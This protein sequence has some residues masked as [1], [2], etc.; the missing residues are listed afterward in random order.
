MR[1]ELGGSCVLLRKGRGAAGQLCRAT[2]WE[3]QPWIWLQSPRS[4]P[5]LY[6]APGTPGAGQT[7]KA[8]QAQQ[9]WLGSGGE[10][11]CQVGHVEGLSPGGDSRH[12]RRRGPT[13]ETSLRHALWGSSSRSGQRSQ[14]RSHHPGLRSGL[15]A[16]RAPSPRGS[17][18][19]QLPFRG[20]WRDN[21][22]PARA[23]RS[24]AARTRRRGPGAL[25]RR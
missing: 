6:P 16:A 18:G 4:Q 25:G 7:W 2:G 24:W 8:F 21:H 1:G 3:P 19:R 14:G 17:A 5:R 12:W 11:V 23:S 13:W 15:W 22:L 9:A 10:A 20:D